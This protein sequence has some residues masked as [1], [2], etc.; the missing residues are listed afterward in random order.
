MNE[1]KKMFEK[2]NTSF[3]WSLY[4][5]VTDEHNSR[6][7]FGDKSVQNNRCGGK[8]QA[9]NFW[10]LDWCL[11]KKETLGGWGHLTSA[12]RNGFISFD[13]LCSY[14]VQVQGKR[15]RPL[16]HHRASLNR[17]TPSVK[18]AEASCS[19]AQR[20]KLRSDLVGKSMKIFVLFFLVLFFPCTF[21]FLLFDA[22]WLV[23]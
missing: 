4:L 6:R 7:G 17:R 18:L 16:W 21:P 10:R 15:L 14:V 5:C 12:E 11:Q 23:R 3:Q 1:L 9:S 13:V 22:D 8:T 20:A 19:G 2:K